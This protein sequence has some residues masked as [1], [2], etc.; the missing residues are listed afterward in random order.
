MRLRDRL[1]V[2]LLTITL[3]PLL[4]C[5][6]I[7]LYQNNKNAENII[8]ENLLGVSES[9]IDNIENFFGKIKQ[10]HGNCV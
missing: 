8:E 3:V 7:L 5:G 9:Q 1:Y 6:F 2:T 4:L 10:G